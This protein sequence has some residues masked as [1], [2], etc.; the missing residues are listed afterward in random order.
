MD[1]KYIKN[2]QFFELKIILLEG[3]SKEVVLGDY[4]HYKILPI[5]PW[6]DTKESALHWSHSEQPKNWCTKGHD[7][8]ACSFMCIF[9]YL[10]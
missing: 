8:S 10:I 2:V 1:I 9:I 6:S 5:Y 4:Y 3:Y 7:G